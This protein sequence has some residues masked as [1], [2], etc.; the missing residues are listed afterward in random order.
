MVTG[1]LVIGFGL[2][3]TNYGLVPMPILYDSLIFRYDCNHQ[4]SGERARACIIDEDM[5]QKIEIKKKKG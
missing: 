4:K 2:F 5:N 3:G 1:I